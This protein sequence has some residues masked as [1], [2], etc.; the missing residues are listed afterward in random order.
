M[1]PGGR[2]G[3]MRAMTA[4]TTTRARDRG[5]ETLTEGIR[6]RV[7]PRYIPHQSDPGE[8]KFIFAYRI[9]IANESGSPVRLM[10]R[11]WD[12]VDAAGRRNEVEG[13]GVVGQRPSLEPGEEFE[14]ES[15]CPI[16]TPWGTMEGWYL[17]ERREG[18]PPIRA[19]IGRFYLVSDEA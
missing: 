4:P 12:I 17:F 14:Y 13:P 15:F 2:P 11:H 3:N 16:A 5:S 1:I 6:V 8:R 10:S 18:G 7:W 9:R 19:I